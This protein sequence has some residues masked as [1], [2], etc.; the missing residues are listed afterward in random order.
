MREKRFN[1][2]SRVLH[3]AI[4][5][6]F[7]YILLT[8]L[9][10]MGWMNKGSMGN[11]IQDNLAEQNITIS[12]DTAATIGKKVRKPMW[13]THIIAGYVMTGLFVVRIILTW[14]QGMGFANPLKSGL[15][16]YEKFKS[17]VYILFYLFLGTSLFTG[18]MKV[19]GPE[20][21][22][23]IMEEI[24]VLSLYFAVPFI[25]LHTF[26]VLI[27]DAGKERGVISKIISGDK[28]L[29]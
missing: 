7:L 24:H 5:F 12:N 22:E 25:V 6:T 19:L 15:S 8:V 9:L 17:W 1:L 10:R 29:Q 16:R 26:G 27:A 21:T 18:L 11:I 2:A 23:H 28:P 13:H 3:W 4:A 14:I 20:S